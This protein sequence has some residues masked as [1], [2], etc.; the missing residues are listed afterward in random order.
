M[1]PTMYLYERA[2]EVHSQDL[3]CEMAESR[4]LSHL[5]PERERSYT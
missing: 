5:L 1:G 4:G 2:R 3:R